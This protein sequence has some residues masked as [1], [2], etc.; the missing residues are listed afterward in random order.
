MAITKTKAA[1]I[2]DVLVPATEVRVL[3]ALVNIGRPA[4][5]PEI[6]RALNDEISDA[7]LYTLLGRLAEQRGLVAREERWIDVQGTRLRRIFWRPHDAS[8]LH[9]RKEIAYDQT[10]GGPQTAG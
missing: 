1:F 4:T 2:G 8:R 5:V 3:G 7:S 9:F 10:S 6:A